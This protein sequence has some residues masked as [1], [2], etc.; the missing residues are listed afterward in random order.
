MAAFRHNVRLFYFV[1][2]ESFPS[3]GKHKSSHVVLQWRDSPS[4]I[5]YM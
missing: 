5:R 2:D 3:P 4:G 1:A